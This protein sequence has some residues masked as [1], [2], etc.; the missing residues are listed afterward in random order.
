MKKFMGKNFLLSTEEAR[1]LFHD[2]AKELP[3]IDYHCHISPKEIFEDR[4]FKNITEVWL[5]GDH[6]KWRIMRAMGVDEK[7]ITGDAPDKEKFQKYA[8]TLEKAIGN[9][10]YHW[11]HMELQRYFNYKG[12]LN[13]ETWEAVWELCNKKLA[14]PSMSVRSLIKKSNVEVI[15]TTDDPAD[16][17]E[18]HKKIAEDPTVDFRVCPAWRPDKAM[19]IE[20][21]DFQDYIA[22]L[23]KASGVKIKDFKSLMKALM[24]RMDFF[25]EMGCR[26]SDHGLD[27]VPYEEA[28]EKEADVIFQKRLNGDIIT[29]NDVR[30]Y[31]TVFLLKM[32]RAYYEKNWV[33]QLHYGCKRNN[34]TAAFDAI[35]PDTGFDAIGNGAP[36]GE[37]A[38]F[39]NALN[40]EGRLPKTIV[41]SLNPND[42]AAID[43]IVGC[44]NDGK[45]A[46][47]MQ[48]GSAWWFND[49]KDGITAQLSTLANE[50]VLGTFVGMLT[51]SRSFLSY[52]RHE[53]FR[54]ILC[55]FIGNLVENGE[56][57]A[58]EKALSG[59]IKGICHDNAKAYFGF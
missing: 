19:G 18:W 58:D 23:Q 11:S 1:H 51:D 24:K 41:Y 38:D 33:M 3:I 35:G 59:I 14:D 4:K 2:I 30:K 54:R 42:N 29:E 53:Y 37:L 50:G 16:S 57:P 49:H 40:T 46:G 44:F 10:L 7:Y 6:Y 13:G 8:Q 31:K 5:S 55:E 9:P 36:L 56:Y 15:C 12:V 17:L 26:V 47:K 22:L 48:H 20:K 28:D 34:N 21:T 25:D 32:G 27:Y 45:I 52:A 43:T 39:L